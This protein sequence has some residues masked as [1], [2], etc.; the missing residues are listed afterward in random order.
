L[1]KSKYED[2]PK[3]PPHNVAKLPKNKFERSKSTRKIEDR[4]TSID[5][6]N[7]IEMAKM[8]NL[9]PIRENESQLSL[10]PQIRDIES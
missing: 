2:E 4:K 8:I 7:I 1:P 10:L 9:P 5:R 6:H 3:L